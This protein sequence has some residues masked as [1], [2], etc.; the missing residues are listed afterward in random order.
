MTHY[1]INE[2]TAV[3]WVMADGSITLSK[4]QAYFLYAKCAKNGD[5]GTFIFSTSQIKVE[6]DANYYHFLIGTISSIDPELKVRSLSLTYGFSMINGRFI[7]TGRIES[8]DGTT[9]FDLDNSEI[10]GRIVFNSNGQEKTLEE[11]GDEAL[12]SKNFINN[13]LPGLLAEMQAQL[14]GQIE[15]FFE[16][17]NPTLS[18]APA[19]EWTTTQLKDNHLGDL[20]YNTATGAVFRFVK[21]NGTYNG[22]NFQMRKSHKPLPLRKMRLI[23]QRI[24]TAYSRQPLTR[25]MKS[26][27]YGFKA[28]PGILCVA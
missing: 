19:N 7:K 26:A 16:T 25:L 11:L 17:Y 9:Y 18:N 28:Q 21:E 3:S 14:D 15:Q 22:R 2:E 24:R 8:A 10:G 23:L 6:Q 4:N 12:E 1:T 27:I 13:T 20:F 5:A